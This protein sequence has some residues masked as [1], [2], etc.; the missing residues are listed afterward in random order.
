MFADHSPIKLERLLL[1]AALTFFIADLAPHPQLGTSST[2]LLW[3]NLQDLFGEKVS[4]AAN[5]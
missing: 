5:P 4:F 3:S 1:A 2:A